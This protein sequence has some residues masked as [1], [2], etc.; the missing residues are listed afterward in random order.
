MNRRDSKTIY[1]RGLP[2]GGGNPI[3]VQ[4]MT[5]THTEDVEATLAQIRRL[6][7]A[8][9]QIVRLAVPNRLAA[10]ALPDIRHGTDMPLVAD[11]HFNP[12]RFGVEVVAAGADILDKA[13]W[14]VFVGQ[15]QNSF[16]SIRQ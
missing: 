4:S 8:G 7:A 13:E 9:C 11:I 10:R 1:V 14:N 12:P 16:G 2:I 6:E 15:Q 3:A 5:N